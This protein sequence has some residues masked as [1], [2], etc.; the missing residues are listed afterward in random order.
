MFKNKGDRLESLIQYVYQ[1][2]SNYSGQKI[3]VKNKQNIMGKMGVPHNIDVYYQF[4]LN[5]ITHRVL[6][7]CKNWNTRVSKEKI[8][9]FKTILDDIPNSV[10]VFVSTKGFQSGAEQSENYYGIEL[11]SGSE[12]S[13]LAIA[14]KKNLQIVLPDEDVVGAPFYCLMEINDDK[15]TTGTYVRNFLEDGEAYLILYFSKLEAE[16]TLTEADTAVRGIDK[17]H[18]E[19][20]CQYSESMNLKLAIKQFLTPQMISVESKLIRDFYL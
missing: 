18:L 15:K 12:S 5:G 8:F 14:V 9:A 6:F 2:L 7:E 17:Y 16:E 4:D 10:G 1:V 20:L 11:I 3:E 13:L 19:V